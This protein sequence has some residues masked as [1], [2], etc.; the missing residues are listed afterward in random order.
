MYDQ[1][2]YTNE[3]IIFIIVFFIILMFIMLL[4]YCTIV[5]I[6]KRVNMITK[7]RLLQNMNMKKY[8]KPC[9]LLSM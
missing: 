2:S 8:D 6:E 3:Y 5:F 4:I 7:I 1:I 9:K